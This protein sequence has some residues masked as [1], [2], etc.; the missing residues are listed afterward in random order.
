MYSTVLVLCMYAKGLGGR[1]APND[2]RYCIHDDTT[3]KKIRY[4]RRTAPTVRGWTILTVTYIVTP[5]SSTTR[6]PD[7]QHQALSRHV[8]VRLGPNTRRAFYS[9]YLD[10]GCPLICMALYDV[11]HHTPKQPA[12]LLK[13][14]QGTRSTEGTAR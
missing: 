8:R 7:R 10:T 5:H 1:L 2:H 6:V 9:G 3:L 12:K 4:R 11:P 13:R 14:M